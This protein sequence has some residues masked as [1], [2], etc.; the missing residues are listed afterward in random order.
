ML[1]AME[2]LLMVTTAI[3]TTIIAAMQSAMVSGDRLVCSE[4]CDSHR[5]PTMMAMAPPIRS[6]GMA[7]INMFL[8][9]SFTIS[10]AGAVSYTH[11]RAHET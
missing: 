3:S 6:E 4:Y 1:L 9:N 2:R 5:L 8:Q 10:V 7:T 11:L